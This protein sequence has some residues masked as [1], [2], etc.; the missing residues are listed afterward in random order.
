MWV[1][2]DTIISLN[3]CEVVNTYSGCIIPC[4]LSF[5]ACAMVGV[6]VRKS[7]LED[8]RRHAS[9]FYWA[10]VSVCVA[11]KLFFVLTVGYC[12]RHIKWYSTYCTVLYCQRS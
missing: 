11:S 3:E 9:C 5:D 4:K 1:Q 7:F 2:V 6:L 12:V 8:G 10:S